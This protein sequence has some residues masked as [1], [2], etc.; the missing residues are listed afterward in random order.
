MIRV[1]SPNQVW[2]RFFFLFNLLI[3]TIACTTSEI[4][5]NRDHSVENIEILASTEPFS[6][7]TG[8]E[9]NRPVVITFAAYEFERQLYE[10]LM[11]EFHQ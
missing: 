11:S 6:I 4:P 3:N 10:P 9:P 5:A 2:V 7:S 8:E 1:H